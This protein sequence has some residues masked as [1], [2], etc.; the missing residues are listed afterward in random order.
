[1][2]SPDAKLA[3]TL[4]KGLLASGFVLAAG[5]YYFSRPN[6]DVPPIETPEPPTV[7]TPTPTP[8]PDFAT[9]ADECAMEMIERR[10]LPMIA[11]KTEGFHLF[12]SIEIHQS[13]ED[14]LQR[15]DDV[16]AYQLSLCEET[17]N[18]EIT[19]ASDE[20]LQMLEDA[21][22]GFRMEFPNQ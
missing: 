13:T 19:S 9:A 14:F 4:A 7:V 8:A 6:D 18:T 15:V 20:H 12:N 11:N 3:M 2:K 5:F 1:M 10:M 21:K 22:Q 17:T 16:A